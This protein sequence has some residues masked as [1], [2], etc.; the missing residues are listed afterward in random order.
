MD[1]WILDDYDISALMALFYVDGWI[2]DGYCIFALTVFFYTDRGIVDGY[3][4]SSLVDGAVNVMSLYDNHF[5]FLKFEFL[6]KSH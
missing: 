6:M 4:I 2:V 5:V 1:G 3:G